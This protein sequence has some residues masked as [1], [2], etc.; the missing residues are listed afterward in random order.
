MGIVTII[1]MILLGLAG[2]VF[3]ILAALLCGCIAA[4]KKMPVGKFAA[5]GA[6]YGLF[7]VPWIYLAARMFDRQVPLPILGMIYLFPYALW[8][9]FL[10]GIGVNIYFLWD[11]R[12]GSYAI[13]GR[14]VSSG[15]LVATFLLFGCIAA[16]CLLA[17]ARSVREIYLRQREDRRI[18]LNNSMPSIAYLKP[19]IYA[20]LWFCAGGLFAAFVTASVLVSGD[21]DIQGF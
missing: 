20:Y 1:V 3:S 18:V 10:A 11:Y 9:C 5:A 6:L 12:L 7:I 19:F 15:S 14:G 8:L 4:Y 17:L 13:E 16:V 2:L 21:I